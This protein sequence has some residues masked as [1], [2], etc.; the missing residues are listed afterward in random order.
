MFPVSKLISLCS[1]DIS[2]LTGFFNVMKK[3]RW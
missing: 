2:L 3:T 1:D